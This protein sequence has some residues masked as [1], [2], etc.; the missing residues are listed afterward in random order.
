MGH[1]DSHAQYRINRGIGISAGGILARPGESVQWRTGC[2]CHLA[3][4]RM[5]LK[6]AHA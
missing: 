6:S 3:F 5:A 4:H 1:G 2:Q